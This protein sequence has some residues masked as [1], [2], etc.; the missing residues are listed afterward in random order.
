TGIAEDTVYQTKY[1]LTEAE[2]TLTFESKYII[3]STT[4]TSLRTYLLAQWK[5][6]HNQLEF[7]V[8]VEHLELDIGDILEF[9]NMPFKIFGED[10]TDNTTTRPLGE[11][12]INKYWWI[13]KFK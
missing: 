3:D 5:Q 10:I 11:Q 9:S 7:G 2:S 13:Y 1:N 12:V 8:G 6:P 4:A